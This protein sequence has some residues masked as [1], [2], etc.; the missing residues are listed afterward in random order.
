VLNGAGWT[1]R[2]IAMDVSLLDRRD[3]DRSAG[4]MAMTSLTELAGLR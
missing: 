4:T 1:A 2:G 3:F